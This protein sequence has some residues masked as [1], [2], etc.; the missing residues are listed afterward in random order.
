MVERHADRDAV[1]IASDGP[2]CCPPDSVH[3]HRALFN[4]AEVLLVLPTAYNHSQSAQ[5]SGIETQKRR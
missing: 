5:K 2:T 4:S 3:D 1:L